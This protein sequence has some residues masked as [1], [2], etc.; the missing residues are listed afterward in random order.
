MP[1]R[2]GDDNNKNNNHKGGDRKRKYSQTVSNPRRG[3][4][5]FLF[6][7]GMGRERK[8]QREALALL[9]HYHKGSK[10]E[11]TE[12]T[13]LSLE[14]EIAQVLEASRDKE[15]MD[16]RVF[17]TG[18]KGVVV[19]LCNL[20][21]CYV[22]PPLVLPRR[23]RE[24]WNDDNTTTN[25]NNDNE[26]DSSKKSP[27][28]VMDKVVEET[29]KDNTNDDDDDDNDTE[30]QQQDTLT[31]PP[32]KA[33]METNDKRTNET[34]SATTTNSN[35]TTT[36]TT[37]NS[38][39]IS[40]TELT[41]NA[42]DPVPLVQTVV[43]DLSDQHNTSTPGFRFLTRM[44]PLQTTCYTNKEEIEHAAKLLFARQSSPQDDDAKRTNT[45]AVRV[46]RRNCSQMT[47]Q[48]AI[49][50]IASQADRERWRVDLK[51]PMFTMVVEI[52][53]SLCGMALVKDCVKRFEKFNLLE[54]KEK[55]DIGT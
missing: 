52:C 15:N 55:R 12:E 28:K 25:D 2:G 16:F 7:V 5:G 37:N 17:E 29:K 47:S 14:D 1:K 13:P 43:N 26:G 33:K 9:Q 8:C 46:T 20:P 48:H 18:C 44:I 38:N 4:P 6:T 23:R 50:W 3:P 11:E 35:T 30:Q 39:V 41:L 42:W 49:V 10:K 19:I 24:V 34:E 51:E 54:L 21:N 32:K 27:S 31:V 40:A 45:F 36:T 53:K 22:V